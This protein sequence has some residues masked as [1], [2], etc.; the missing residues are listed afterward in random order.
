MKDGLQSE[1]YA[2][3]PCV[4][5]CNFHA[6]T[7]SQRPRSDQCCSWHLLILAHA[8]LQKVASKAR[9]VLVCSPGLQCHAG[10]HPKPHKR[11]MTQFAIRHLL[12]AVQ[13]AV[14]TENQ[15]SCCHRRSAIRKPMLTLPRA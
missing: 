15:S 12:I 14:D 11:A 10:A 3:D 6:I 13:P 1:W 9:R 2:A 4:F 5:R 8:D 7:L